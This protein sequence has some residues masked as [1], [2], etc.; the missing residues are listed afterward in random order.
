ME[1]AAMVIRGGTK[2][3]SIASLFKNRPGSSKILIG[4]A[5][6]QKNPNWPIVL[7]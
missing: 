4:D 3:R 2:M 6:F 1:A 5:R 7:E